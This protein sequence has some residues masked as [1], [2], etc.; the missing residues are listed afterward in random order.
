M[1]SE[2]RVGEIMTENPI[3][4]TLPGTRADVLRLL[5]THKVTGV[6]VVKDD[7]TYAGIVARKHFFAKPEEDQLAL[8]MVKEAPS[9]SP[10]TPVGEVVRIMLEG[11]FHHIAVCEDS[12]VVGI[13]TPTDIFPIVESLDISTP[14]DQVLETVCVPV[15]EGTPLEAANEIMRVA[16]VFAL[17]V[18]DDSGRLTGIITDRDVFNLSS[19]NGTSAMRDMGLAAEENP[20][21][22]EGLRN[23]MKLYYEERKV[24][25]PKVAV[26]DVM[27]KKVTTVSSKTSVSEAARIMHKNDFGQLPVK[28]PHDRLLG[29]LTE[30]DVIRVLL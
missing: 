5:V 4:G 26:R 20:W 24:E 11:D 19:I 13:V 7:G 29:L 3:V 23:V 9:V 21:S 16:H 30:M 17:P 25:L 10:D 15:Y 27:V 18:L 1:T 6:P 2:E 12:K 28:D 14:V 22:W 8:L